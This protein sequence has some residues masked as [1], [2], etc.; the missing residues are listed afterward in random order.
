MLTNISLDEMNGHTD[1]VQKKAQHHAKTVTAVIPALRGFIE[2]F[3]TRITGFTQNGDMK[4]STWFVSKK[5][6]TRYFVGYDHS[7]G[8]INIKL[9]DRRGA[10]MGSVDNTTSNVTLLSLFERL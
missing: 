3:G 4:N 2:T 7:T 1:R 9:H 8:M 6:G 10:I 5:T